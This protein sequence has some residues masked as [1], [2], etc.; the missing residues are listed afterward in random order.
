LKPLGNGADLAVLVPLS[1]FDGHG[2][3][4][5]DSFFFQATQSGGDNGSDEWT[6]SDKGIADTHTPA[7]FSP[8][9]EISSGIIPEPG[10]GV[11]LGAG[12]L[13]LALNVRR[14]ASRRDLG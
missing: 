7:I 6:L 4:E 14:N 8:D 1:V 2:L 5:A 11:L 10:T 12:L 13:A 9:Q 3:T